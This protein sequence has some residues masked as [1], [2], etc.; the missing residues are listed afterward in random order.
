MT[1][2]SSIG[3]VVIPIVCTVVLKVNV[4]RVFSIEAVIRIAGVLTWN[5]RRRNRR[6]VLVWCRLMLLMMVNR[7]V[8]T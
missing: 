1:I 2:E 5:R 3:I 4:S 7:T 8:V 6:A